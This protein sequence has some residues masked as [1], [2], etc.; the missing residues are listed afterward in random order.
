MAKQRTQ[1]VCQT[2]GRTA[3]GFLGRCPRCG[4]FDTMVEE[5]I[6]EPSQVG[7]T[8]ARISIDSVPQRLTE[9]TADGV[10]RLNLP[11]VEFSRVLGGGIVPG[12]LVLVGGDPG[13]GKSTLLLE[14]SSQ[15]ARQ[16]GTTLYVSGEES[17]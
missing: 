1:F 10:E 4:E 16:Y 5:V 9:I 12:S 17:L 15:V 13:I 3:P 11:S 14:I 2:C 6:F 7:A 8:K